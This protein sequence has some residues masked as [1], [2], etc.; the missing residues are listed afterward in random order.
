M[1]TKLRPAFFEALNIKDQNK[2]LDLIC[3]FDKVIP[4]M[5]SVDD[6]FV[7]ELWESLKVLWERLKRSSW[8]C[9]TA[10]MKTVTSLK[11][12]FAKCKFEDYLINEFIAII[13]NGHNQSKSSASHALCIMLRQENIYKKMDA[14]LSELLKLKNSKSCLERTGYIEFA[15]AS[16]YHFSQRF[17]NEQ[18]IIKELS[19]F[20]NDKIPIMRIRLIKASVLIIDKLKEDLQKILT[21]NISLLCNDSSNDVKS[22]AKKAIKYFRSIDNSKTNEELDKKNIM[23]ENEEDKLLGIV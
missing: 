16:I 6:V 8:R 2:L 11:K 19:D 20:T 21:D 17:L 14:Y 4:Q 23:L 9:M 1:G 12:V 18:N 7:E 5:L 3:S 10:F 15:K 13:R 22:E